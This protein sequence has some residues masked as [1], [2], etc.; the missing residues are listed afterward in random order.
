MATNTYKSLLKTTVS[1]SSTTSVTLDLTGITG[2]TD[3][4]LVMKSASSVN[5]YT[6]RMRVNG[7][8]GTNYSSTFFYGTGSTAASS[9]LTSD[10]GFK[11]YYGTIGQGTTLDK[12]NMAVINFMNYKNTNTYKTILA[13]FQMQNDANSTEVR[14]TTQIWRNTAAITSI[15]LDNFGASFISGST[16]SLYGITAATASTVKATGGTITYDTNGNVIHTFTS[17]GTFTPN[18]ALTVD[19]LVVAGGGSGGRAAIGGSGTGGG[20]AG[21]YRTTVGTSGGGSSPESA[22]ALTS[23]T[24]YTVTVGA[25]GAATTTRGPGTIGSN[26]VFS[27]ITSTGGGRGGNESNNNAGIG[28][29]GGGNGRDS[30]TGAAGTTNQGYAGGGNSGGAPY[31]GGGGGGA[32][33]VGVNGTTN[34]NGGAGI[35]SVITGLSVTRAGGGGGGIYDTSTNTG[36]SGGAGGGGGGGATV[37]NSST[38]AVAGTANTG[39]GGGGG[40]CSGTDVTNGAAGGSGIVIIRYAG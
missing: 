37:G 30:A 33:A 15:V 34:G 4:V 32:G 31:R 36:G 6:T 18:Q 5:N 38:N 20:G 35:A 7:D 14:T 2:Y 13:K 40:A 25:G 24:A 28:G 26:S 12:N 9:N 16:F 10:S 19:Y 22:L 29:S 21:G 11:I 39:G 17:S 1:G 27:S 23:G 3:L 8:S